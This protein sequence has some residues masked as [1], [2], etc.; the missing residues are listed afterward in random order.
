MS[1]KI[2]LNTRHGATPRLAACTMTRRLEGRGTGDLGHKVQ[3]HEDAVPRRGGVV[4]CGH[5]AVASIGQRGRVVA[6]AWHP[7]IMASQLPRY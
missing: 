5:H 7:I 3:R 2:K 4:P 6:V 1:R